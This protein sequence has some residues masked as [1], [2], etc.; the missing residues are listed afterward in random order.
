MVELYREAAARAGHDPAELPISINSHGFLA[1][2]EATAAD[3]AFPPFAEVM[4]RI[5]RERGWPPTT[6]QRF[7]A[8]RGP[9]GALLVGS[10][11]QVIDK[12]LYEYELF[13]HQRFLV[14][15]TVGPMPHAEVMRAIEILGTDVAPVVRREVGGNGR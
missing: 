3:V 7:E 14:Q 2:D 6:R 8:E 11:Q 10:P 1:A 13:R 15:L 12:M 9:R 5:G 4:T